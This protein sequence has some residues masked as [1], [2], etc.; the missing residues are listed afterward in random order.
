MGKKSQSV[1][2]NNSIFSS[3]LSMFGF[4]QVNVCK[5][6]DDSF[7]C[8]F[9]RVFQLVIAMLVIVAILYVVYTFVL[10]PLILKNANKGG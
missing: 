1:S 7:Y 3:L 10:K 4:R 9:M 2:A 5:D 8:K 6:E